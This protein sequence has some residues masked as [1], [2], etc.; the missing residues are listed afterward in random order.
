[1][2]IYINKPQCFKI[3]R[4]KYVVVLNTHQDDNNDKTIICHSNGEFESVQ[5]EKLNNSYEKT[6]LINHLY[7]NTSL[8]EI[9]LEEGLIEVG[10][11]NTDDL[12]YLNYTRSY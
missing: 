1:M 11:H 7:H 2:R 10:D 3:H 9:S 8:R 12:N 6:H 4:N 5:T